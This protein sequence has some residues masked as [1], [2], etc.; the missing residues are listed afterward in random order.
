M[1]GIDLEAYLA[2]IDYQGPREPTLGTL[3]RSM[4]RT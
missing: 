2:R 3:T 1:A 4:P